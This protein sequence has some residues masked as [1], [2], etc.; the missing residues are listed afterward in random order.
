MKQ[1]KRT[2]WELKV[3]VFADFGSLTQKD[4]A[5]STLKVL[6]ESWG[7]LVDLRHQRNSLRIIDLDL[8][9]KE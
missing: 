2:F 4:L 7:H 5:V 1:D 6:L 9:P 3:R 8:E